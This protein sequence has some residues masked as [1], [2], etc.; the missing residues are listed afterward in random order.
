MV[1]TLNGGGGQHKQEGVTSF[2]FSVKTGISNY[3]WAYL[4]YLLQTRNEVIHID[5]LQIRNIM[6]LAYVY[7]PCYKAC[8]QSCY[9]VV[10]R[11]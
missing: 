4:A 11:W 2:S 7:L 10:T 8:K 1:G 9:K 3:M 5:H 6:I